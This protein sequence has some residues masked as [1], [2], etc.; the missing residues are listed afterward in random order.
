MS[1]ISPVIDLMCEEGGASFLVE[2]DENTSIDSLYNPC[3][4]LDDEEKYIEYLFTQ[5][6]G[7][8]SPSCPGLS[9]NHDCSNRFWLRS[10]RL[11]AIDWIFITQAKF[12]FKVHTAY[13]SI[14]YLDQFLSK[15]SIDESKPWAI[16]LLSVAC[17]SLAAKM[18]EQ[19]VPSLS[20][21]PSEEYRFQN[22][23][24]KNMEIMILSTLEWKMGSVTPFPYLHYFVT[25]FCPGSRPETIITKAIDYIV[26]L[27][28]DINLMDQRPSII[29]SAAVLAAFDA[30]LT[31]NAI[32]LMISAISS[33]G[34]IESGHVFSCYNLIQEKKRNK[35]KTP[36]SNLFSTHSTSTCVVENPFDTSSGTKRKHPFE[37][38]KSCPGQK[39]HRP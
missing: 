39:L 20:E 29:A 31:R 2:Y 23:V 5:E 21:Y 30:T 1:N 33:W 14:T 34:N 18:E 11:D 25:K 27:V 32:D 17:L 6:M 3:F 35:V 36:S 9:S 26:A 12:G 13:L 7:F 8:L 15:R 16:K 37:N 28:K 22:R 24:I 19:N 38:S 10:A 4:I